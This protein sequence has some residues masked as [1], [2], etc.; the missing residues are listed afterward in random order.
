VSVPPGT[1]VSRRRPSLV[2]RA[3]QR[4]FRALPLLVWA[5]AAGGVA[6][7]LQERSRPLPCKALAE[8]GRYLV[9]TPLDAQ[10]AAWN[11][12]ELQPVAAGQVLGL[13]HDE[14][15]R[16]QLARARLDL[17]QLRAELA[18]EQEA[19]R[20]DRFQ[21]QAD[22]DVELRRLHG[23]ADTARVDALRTRAEIEEARVLQQGFAADL[24]RQEALGE[25]IA[26]GTELNR[27]RTERDRYGRR[28]QELQEL[29]AGQEQRRDHA[30]SRL[31]AFATTSRPSVDDAVL[32]EPF[33][34]R[35][36]EQEVALEE[37]ALA[38]QQHRLIAP[39]DGIV[40]Q[41]W[42]RRGERVR[43]GD[44]LATIVEPRARAV[45]AWVPETLRAR[46]APGMRAALE[47]ADLPGQL[48][49]T[50][51]TRVAPALTKVPERLW[52]DP[53]VEE[54]A[55]PVWFEAAG[56]ELPGQRMLVHWR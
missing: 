4:T 41:V 33:R 45:V 53:R 23:D 32:S 19:R 55:V 16:L 35:I 42:F 29:L 10:I 7:L 51:V 39:A 26:T 52:T 18:A 43:A 56:D 46:I 3:R 5:A 49:P 40:E 13:L 25:H 1:G 36:R 22:R 2:A 17:E 38:L 34:F 15:I 48:R 30:A 54:W 6:L 28:V 14:A 12:A 50:I 24:Q 20:Q 47:R 21:S 37:I 9:H 11:V 27:L 8:T 44:T 31:Q